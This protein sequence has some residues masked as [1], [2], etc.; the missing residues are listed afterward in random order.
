MPNA[1]AGI[2]ISVIVYAMGSGLIEVLVSPIVEACPFENKK[3]CNE[4]ASF[5]LLLGGGRS[6]TFIDSILSLHLE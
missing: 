2:I 5:I 1:Y 3:Q 6:H 4:P